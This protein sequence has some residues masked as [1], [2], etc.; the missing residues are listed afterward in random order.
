MK[1]FGKMKLAAVALAA[2]VGLVLPAAAATGPMKP[3]VEA[4]QASTLLRGIR[5][6]AKQIQEHAL[7]LD[8]LSATAAPDW[9]ACDRQWN[10][11]KP[12][13]EIISMRLRRLESIESALPPRD[14]KAV[15]GSRPLFGEIETTTHEVRALLDSNG[16]ISSQSSAVLRARSRALA[17]AARE[18]VQTAG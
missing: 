13:V 3:A 7:Q 4:H 15:A 11:I 9:Q 2:S 6:D 18:L 12:A 17:K 1:Y 8:K 16:T 5:V 10:K 14:Q